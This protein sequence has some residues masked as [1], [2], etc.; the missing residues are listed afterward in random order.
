M[1]GRRRVAQ[2]LLGQAQ[3]PRQQGAQAHIGRLR[4]RPPQIGSRAFRR[5]TSDRPRRGRLQTLHHLGRSGRLAHEQVRAH[6]VKVRALGGQQPRRLG[7]TQTP[8]GPGDV[9]VYRR[10]HD[11]VHE[12]QRRARF[13][14]SDPGQPVC[15]RRGVRQ[16]HPGQH[17]SVPQLRPVSEYRGRPR[18]L[19][20]RRTQ[21]RNP[22]RHRPRNRSRTQSRYL[23]SS[24]LI[25]ADPVPAQ[26]LDQLS[27]QE[28]VTAGHRVARLGESFRGRGP[29]LP[30]Q[31]CPHTAPAERSQGNHAVG[32][33]LLDADQTIRT[34][35]ALCRP[36]GKR[37]RHW[38]PGQPVGQVEHEPQRRLIGP[39]QIIHRHQ[40]R[41]RRAGVHRQPVQA[42]HHGE[43]RLALR[44][45]RHR[46]CL[47]LQRDQS[48]PR[49][50]G[51]QRLPLRRA[52]TDEK[53]LKQLPHHTERKAALQL[54]AAPGQHP[55]FRLGR[56][57]PRR[58]Q[59]HGLADPGRTGDEQHATATGTCSGHQRIDARQFILTL[60]QSARHYT[61]TP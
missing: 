55:H 37:Q 28:R 46:T 29:E 54:S 8:A 41:P 50:P 15:R 24:P 16:A 30:D 36:P 34:V 32:G 51:Q 48:P 26:L 27:Q 53:R 60:A 33:D 44:L 10:A 6:R 3:L 39:V 31:Q 58:F 22:Q 43:R 14:H 12:P 35:P 42:V 20:R 2:H 7:V 17:R 61:N 4:H 9:V 11:R 59:Q 38:Q 40:K 47:V 18:Q 56:A 45:Q 49:R 21:P 57:L 5:S 1:L 13:E 52:G 25:G 23:G 19:A